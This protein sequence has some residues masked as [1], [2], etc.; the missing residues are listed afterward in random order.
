ME[1]WKAEKVV[2]KLGFSRPK[3]YTITA[4]EAPDSVRPQ[5][6][7]NLSTISSIYPSFSPA[8]KPASTWMI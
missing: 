5:G 7:Q 2:F 6:W 3:R 4:N 8:G 1:Y